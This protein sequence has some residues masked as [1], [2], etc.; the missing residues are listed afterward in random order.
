MGKAASKYWEEALEGVPV[1]CCETVIWK[2]V[3]GNAGPPLVLGVWGLH[4]ILA[5]L[6]CRSSGKKQQAGRACLTCH[7]TPI[8]PLQCSS[9]A[10]THTHPTAVVL[11]RFV[12][13]GRRKAP[14]P[15]CHFSTPNPSCSIL[16]FIVNP[17]FYGQVFCVHLILP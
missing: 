3:M 5:E 7:F 12:V 11:L 15:S 8:S 14:A 2:G 17:G 16:H 10:K 9:H 13:P 4:Q 6:F 1:G